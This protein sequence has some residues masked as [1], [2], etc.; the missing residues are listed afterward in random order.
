MD[1]ERGDKNRI[2]KRKTDKGREANKMR[3][4]EMYDGK[5]AG[6]G[7]QL[8]NGLLMAG[9]SPETWLLLLE[10]MYLDGDGVTVTCMAVVRRFLTAIFSL[11]KSAEGQ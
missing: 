1:R 8:W 11:S 7:R 5:G 2:K 3:N 4:D 6:R 10:L 9:L